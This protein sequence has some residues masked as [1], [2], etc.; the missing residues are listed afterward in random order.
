MMGSQK[1]FL[2]RG[3]KPGKMGFADQQHTETGE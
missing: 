1:V 3:A 2:S